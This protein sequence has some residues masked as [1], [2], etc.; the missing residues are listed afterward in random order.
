MSRAEHT[1]AIRRPTAEVFAWITDPD[2][3]PLWQPA[4][5]EVRRLTD[6]PIRVGWRF[7]E[8]RRLLGRSI[9]SVFEVTE[10]DPPHR[11]AVTV[12]D[13]PVAGEASYVL[14]EIPDG[15]ELRFAYQLDAAGFLRVAEQLVTRLVVREFEASLG[16]LKDLLEARVG[17]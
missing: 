7:T 3:T 4:L 14:R 12:V 5:V 17:A 11:S 8:V 13:G 16:H 10:L 9:G 15:T 2:N 6:G 1:I